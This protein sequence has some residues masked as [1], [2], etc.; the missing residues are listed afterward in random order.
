MSDYS[1]NLRIELIT[2]GTQAGTWGTTTNTNLGT[3]LEDSIAGYVSVPVSAANQA[4]S[5]SYGAVDQSRNAML[6]LYTSGIAT[7]F[8][9]YVPPVSKQYIVWNDSLYTATI[10]NSDSEGSTTPAGVGVTLSAGKKMVVF[11]DGTDFYSIDAGITSVNASG[12]T[13]GLTFTGG[14]ITESGTLTLG[15]TLAIANGGTSATTAPA[16]RTALG[17]TTVGSN[18]FTLP[19]PSAVRYIQLNADNTVTVMDAATF[20]AAIGGGTGGGTV[21]SVAVSGTNITVS[22]SPITTNGTIS[23]SIPQSVAT[24][25]TPQFS[26]LGLGTSAG[27]AGSLVATGN[28]TAYYSD[29]RLKT[30]VGDIT[31]ALEAVK[32]IET[33]RYHANEKAVELGYDASLIEVG[34]TAQSVQAVLPE[35]VAPAPVSAEYLT[36]H[37]ERLV[38]LLI[39]AIKELSD[40]VKALENK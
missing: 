3:I 16:A 40:K 39:E 30:K 1:N 34:V 13:T 19:N 10:Y 20:L 17:A 6:R 7:N 24:N 11:S 33:M 14:P 21:T 22:G 36:V 27:G 9:V 8:A 32:Q 23:I 37:Y 4:L 38:P 31:N 25:A 35:A 29:A 26:S 15:G 2:T 5:V 28:I 18:L 12:G